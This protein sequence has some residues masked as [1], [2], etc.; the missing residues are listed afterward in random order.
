MLA[1]LFL[2]LFLSMLAGCS[3]ESTSKPARSAIEE[4]LISTAAERAADKLI[5]QIP[6][7]AKVFVDSSNFEG[8]DSKYA[9][10]AIRDSLLRQGAHLVDDRKNAQT[11]IEI[12][13]GALSMEEKTFLIGIPSFNI[14]I[15]LA[16]TSLPF[17]EIALYKS[18]DQE[19]V[20]KFAFTAYDIKEGTLR[21]SVAPQFGFSHDV[22]K[23]ILIFYSWSTNDIFPE[24]QN[25]MFNEILRPMD[26]D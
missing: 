13:S 24:K 21:E 7:P 19:G 2:A 10:S 4:L 3:T 26:E 6:S 14:P 11:V 5:V 25:T 17:P 1:R 23:T 20:A 12:R 15:P 22:Q 8:T 9:I 18:D 16:S